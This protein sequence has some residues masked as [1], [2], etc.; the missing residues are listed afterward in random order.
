[1]ICAVIETFECGE[2][3]ECERGLAESINL[4]QFLKI[5]FKEKTIT[6]TLPNGLVRTTEIKSMET[7][8]GKLIL[9]G[10]VLGVVLQLGHRIDFRFDALNF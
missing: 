9:Q 1:M 6:G 8:V 2:G 4:P 7:H 3:V 10:I 5:D